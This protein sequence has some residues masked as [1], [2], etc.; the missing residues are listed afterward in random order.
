M[1]RRTIGPR[2]RVRLRYGAHIDDDSRTL[3]VQAIEC[4]RDSRVRI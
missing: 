3:C 2:V 1:Y 4:A